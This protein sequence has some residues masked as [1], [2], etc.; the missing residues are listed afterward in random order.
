L[1]KHREHVEQ[2]P[3]FVG[4]TAR[5]EDPETAKAMEAWLDEFGPDGGA[6]DSWTQE[7]VESFLEVPQH[8][9]IKNM[10]DLNDLGVWRDVAAAGLAAL[11][12]YYGAVG[13]GEA[14]KQG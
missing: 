12:C 6:G 2:V 1:S 7:E 13:H 5:P 10:V 9:L 3:T 11:C 4:C 8:K 14:A